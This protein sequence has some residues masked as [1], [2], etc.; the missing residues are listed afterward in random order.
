M[1][2][3]NMNFDLSD[4]PGLT[5]GP[6]SELKSKKFK[7]RGE[8]MT[9]IR[10][11]QLKTESVIKVILERVECPTAKGCLCKF[12]FDNDHRRWDEFVSVL[13]GSFHLAVPLLK[14]ILLRCSV[15]DVI[16][17]WDGLLTHVVSYRTGELHV[18]SRGS[19]V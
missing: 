8:L 15:S 1:G 3:L 7:K 11:Y 13:D 14:A 12:L 18:P 10:F 2:I 4:L 19:P 6:L 5:G 9:K 17:H 16:A